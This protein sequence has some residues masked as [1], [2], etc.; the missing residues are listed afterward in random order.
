MVR[1]KQRDSEHLTTNRNPNWST[2]PTGFCKYSRAWSPSNLSFLLYWLPSQ[3]WLCLDPI[4]VEMTRLSNLWE[5]S[6]PWRPSISAQLF[7]KKLLSAPYAW[8]N[9]KITTRLCSSNAVS[10]TYSIQSAW[11]KWS[12]QEITNARCVGSN[13]KYRIH[14]FYNENI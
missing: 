4:Q 2:W 6:E 9:S 1:S 3:W 5:W 8:V 14:L 13:C 10:I 7:S 11:R 12:S